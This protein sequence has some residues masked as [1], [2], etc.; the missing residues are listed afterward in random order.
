MQELEYEISEITEI[1]DLGIVDDYVY[2]IGMVDTPHTFF[3]NN[4]LI[5]NSLFLSVIPIIKYRY[6]YVDIADETVMTEHTL[7]FASEI[8]SHVNKSMDYLS[9]KF[10]NTETHHFV[11]KQ[12]VIAVT[13]IWTGK[14]RYALRII[15]KEGIVTDELET[16]GLDTVR[17][18]FPMAFKKFLTQFLVDL[19]SDKFDKSYFDNQILDLK[20]KLNTFKYYEIARTTS[21][22]NINK[23]KSIDLF[24]K[25]KKG[26]PIGVTA[27]LNYNNFL[28]HYNLVKN[29]RLLESGDKVKYV[30]LKTNP[31]RFNAIGFKNSDEDPS[32]VIEY[33]N[34]YIDRKKIFEKEMVNKL[35]S[36]YN[37]MNWNV[38]PEYSDE[39]IDEFFSF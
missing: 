3:A 28:E 25:S 35:N 24:G 7:K 37:S 14:K 29:F 19:L 6:P 1:E 12:E 17:S 5:H 23:F 36:F 30:Y 32:E 8:Q 38:I 21:V 10:F 2:D 11:M 13:G 18:S 26:T 22:N 33:I 16:K 20:N 39:G 34:N 31:F 4:I 15:N 9:K 27:A